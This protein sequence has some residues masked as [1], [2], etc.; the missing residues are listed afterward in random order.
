MLYEYR[1]TVIKVVDGDTIDVRADLGFDVHV[2]MRLR[3]AG[4]DAPERNTEAGKMAALW[5]SDRLPAGME[6][7][8]RTQKDRREKFGRYL[9]EVMTGA[10][11]VTLN[12]MM[13]ANGLA[14]PYGGGKRAGL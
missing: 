9:A 8:I 12:E 1:A 14:K 6:I 4:I 2:S 13:V 5:L 10:G 3:L 7:I 11:E